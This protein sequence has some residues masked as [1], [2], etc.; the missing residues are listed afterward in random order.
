VTQTRPTCERLSFEATFD[1]VRL[2]IVGFVCKTT[3]S[4][5]THRR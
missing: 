1:I 3:R 4:M 5:E 2:L